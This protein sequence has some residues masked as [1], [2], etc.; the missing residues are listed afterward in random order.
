VS[1]PKYTSEEQEILD[2]VARSR[3]QEYVDK[4]AE[5]ILGQARSIR[6]LDEV[7]APDVI[8]TPEWRLWPLESAGDRGIGEADD[9]GEARK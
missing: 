5:L 4:F 7:P 1:T 2:F 6:Q 8:V 3:G 9:G